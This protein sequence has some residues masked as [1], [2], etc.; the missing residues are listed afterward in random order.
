MISMKNQGQ[1]MNKVEFSMTNWECI[2]G[3]ERPIA[4]SWRIL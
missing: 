2:V 4:H 3:Y 1:G